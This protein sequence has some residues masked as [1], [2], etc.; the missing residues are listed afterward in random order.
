MHDDEAWLKYPQHHKWFNKLWLSEQLNY[1]CGPS[2]VS[3]PEE[4]EYFV[5]PIYNLGKFFCI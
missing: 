3:V 5:K 2:S 1:V 4:K